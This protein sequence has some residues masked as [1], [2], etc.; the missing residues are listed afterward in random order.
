MNAKGRLKIFAR[1][2]RWSSSGDLKCLTG[3]LDRRSPGGGR[4]QE[5][6][7]TAELVSPSAAKSQ[8]RVHWSAMRPPC[9]V[10]PQDD[11]YFVRSRRL[12]SEMLCFSNDLLVVQVAP[13]ED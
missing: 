6:A 5:S 4:P 7:A 8:T 10:P 13:L 9:A 12:Q 1:I 11:Q 2:F 3:K